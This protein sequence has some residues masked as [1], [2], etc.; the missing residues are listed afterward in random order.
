MT[1][2]NKLLASAVVAS[3]VALQG[4]GS[5]STTTSPCSS[6]SGTCTAIQPSMPEAQIQSALANLPDGS[7]VAFAAGTYHFQNALA[8]NANNLTIQGA[9]DTQTILDFAA[10]TS[11][12]AGG[13]G[14]SSTGNDFYIHDIAIKDP[15]GNGVKMSKATNVHVNH[16]RVYW[17]NNGVNTNGPYGIYPVACTNVLVEN[18][19]SAGASDT[20]IYVG[21]SQNIIVRNN[22]AENNVMGVEIENC[23]GADVHDNNLHGNTGGVLVFT[24][25]NLAQKD[26]HAAHVYS[27]I[28]NANNHPNFGYGGMV[29]QIPA[30]SGIVVMA[31]REVE[32]DHNTVTGNDTDGVAV[33]SFIFTGLANTTAPDPAYYPYPQQ[34]YIHDNTFSGNGTA[35]DQVVALG[36]LLNTI[37]GTSNPFPTA[38]PD[39]M[40]DGV[41]DPAA[42]TGANPMGICLGTATPPSFGNLT[43]NQYCAVA[44]DGTPVG[45]C[46]PLNP[47][48]DASAYN[49][50]LPSLPAITVP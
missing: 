9:G 27:N 22:E 10:Q 48:T 43:Q 8:F 2:I 23:W 41:L 46:W 42:G 33:I 11:S 25:P 14:L 15:A 47:S 32:I 3:A 50:T 38:L 37:F 30:G 12:G 1:T 39:V 28:V 24:G 5:S 7:T 40:Y 21:Q 4:C 17:S 16:V 45:P 19:Y 29:T 26:G 13:E 44:S 6:V 35:P 34:V 31:D 20:G 18:S 36:Q 49:C